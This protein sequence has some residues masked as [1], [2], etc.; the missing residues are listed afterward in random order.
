MDLQPG[1]RPSPHP[2][3][4]IGLPKRDP[5]RGRHWIGGNDEQVTVA[6]LYT[7]AGLSLADRVTSRAVL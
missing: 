7:K 1:H 5:S 2:R 6:E 3:S 4:R